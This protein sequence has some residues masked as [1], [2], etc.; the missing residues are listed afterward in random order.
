MAE[1]RKLSPPAVL[2]LD[3]ETSGLWIKTLSIDDPQQPWCPS[4]AACLCTAEGEIVQH[5]SLIVKPEGRTIKDGALKVHGI[6]T[7]TAS[8]LGVPEAR[9]LG[10]LGDMLKTAP[11]DSYLR[12]ATF[13]DFDPRVISSLFARFAIS[14]NKP[15]SAYD[16]LFLRRPLIEFVN[17][18]S[19]YAEQVCKIPSEQ[20]P[21]TF[22][23][24]SLDEARQLILGKQPREGHQSA[25]EDMLDTRDIYLELRKRG[26][27]REIAAA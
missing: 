18:M 9:V 20:V 3:V 5:F 4:I 25:W 12:V 23:F 7:R 27:I 21:G 1:S 17:I 22:K 26:L 24:P 11:L 15:S 13:G 6:T 8:Q 2:F 14:Q 10:L 19:P 16:R